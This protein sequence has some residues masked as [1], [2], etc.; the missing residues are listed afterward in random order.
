MPTKKK[1][2]KKI[3]DLEKGLE[4]GIGEAKKIGRKIMAKAKQVKGKYDKLDDRQKRNIL[5][6]IAAKINKLAYKT[7]F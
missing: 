1:V 4:K 3:S 5:A 2:N 7:R 6:S